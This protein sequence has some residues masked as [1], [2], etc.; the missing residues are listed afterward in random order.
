MCSPIN[1]NIAKDVAS[2]EATV[3]ML[4]AGPPELLLISQLM[5][6]AS[7]IQA[8]AYRYCMFQNMHASSL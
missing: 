7:H 1:Q 8:N 6:H 3:G 5:Q 2:L 4:N